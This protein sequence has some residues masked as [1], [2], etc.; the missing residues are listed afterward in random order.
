ME[1]QIN[2]HTDKSNPLMIFS[3]LSREG[4]VRI[5]RST[6][7]LYGIIML[8]GKF[9]LYKFLRDTPMLLFIENKTCI[10]NTSCHSLDL[11][12]THLPSFMPQHSLGDFELEKKYYL[13]EKYFAVS[14]YE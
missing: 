14:T 11:S 9:D 3:I 7:N 2:N 1:K 13:I 4:N 10:K 8:Q 6:L 5:I 12:P